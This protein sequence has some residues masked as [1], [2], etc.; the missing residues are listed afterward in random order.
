[1]ARFGE[2]DDALPRAVAELGSLRRLT[3]PGRFHSYCNAGYWAVGALAAERAGTT[4]EEA[5]RRRVLEPLGLSRTSFAEPDVRG[6]VQPQP[7]VGGHEPA[8]ARRYPRARRPSGGLTSSAG[9]LIRFAAAHLGGRPPWRLAP[10]EGDTATGGYGLGWAVETV[11]GGGALVARRR[12][13]RLPQPACGRAGA[14]HRLR[15]PDER[16]RR[17]GG[18]CGRSRTTSWPQPA[19]CDGPSRRPCRSRIASSRRL[20]GA[21]PEASWRSG[22]AARGRDRPGRRGDRRVHRRAERPAHDARTLAGATAV[23]GG[24]GPVGGRALRRAA[25]HRPTGVPA[26]GRAIAPPGMSGG[27]RLPAGVAAG[28]PA[29]ARAGVELLAAGGSAADAAV[30]ASLASCV[31]ETVMTGFLGG[32]HAL[33]WDAARGHAQNLDCFCAVPGLDTAAAPAPHGAGRRALR[34]GAPALR[35]R[36]VFLRRPGLPAGLAELHAR[37]DGCPGRTS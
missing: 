4:Y 33:Y 31:A 35:H 22:H 3:A 14:A 32:G 11:D 23:R 5:L 10:A 24:R 29:T 19:G 25:G 27:G 20:A 1:M 18:W 28:H 6:H 12:I 13:R 2:G 9:D 8:P 36:A 7:G 17:R 37:T 26:H 30:G 21:T 16:R 34:R 15:R